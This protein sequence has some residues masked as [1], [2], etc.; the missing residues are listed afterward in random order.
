MCIIGFASG[1][2]LRE[3]APGEY[4]TNEGRALKLEAHEITNILSE[5]CDGARKLRRVER[6]DQT[7][8]EQLHHIPQLLKVR[9][10]ERI[11]CLRCFRPLRSIAKSGCLVGL[12]TLT[13]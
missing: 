11:K 10:H 8:S 4:A 12:G 6:D 5:A 9:G 2:P 13:D 3:I 7:R 1:T